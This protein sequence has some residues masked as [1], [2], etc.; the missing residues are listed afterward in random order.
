MFLSEEVNGNFKPVLLLS[1]NS[2]EYNLY[3]LDAVQCSLETLS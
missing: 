3:V 1:K 2:A